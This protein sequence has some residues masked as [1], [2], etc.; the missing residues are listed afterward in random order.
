MTQVLAWIIMFVVLM[1]ILEHGVFARLESRAFAWRT[2][3]AR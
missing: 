2:S 3:F 1:L